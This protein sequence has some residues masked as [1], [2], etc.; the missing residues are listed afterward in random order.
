M[1][2]YTY[3]GRG[4]DI[5]SGTLEEIG[6][7]VI[8]W[9]GDRATQGNEEPWIELDDEGDT[10]P[11]DFTADEFVAWVAKAEDRPLRHALDALTER[12]I[13]RDSEIVAWLGDA[14]VT[15]E[16]YERIAAAFADLTERYPGADVNDDRI[17]A[18]SAAVRVIIG[19]DTLEAIGRRFQAARAALAAAQVE[20]TG[21][22][23]GSQ[24]SE[25]HISAR[26]GVA[27]E[28]V[29]KALGRR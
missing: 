18:T 22:I 5:V 10:S 9:H 11:R 12:T 7:R 23:V 27:R 14:E 2:T 25:Q 4:G 29:R 16:Q 17:A 8:A 28:T 24:G 19:D 20:L 13:D 21:G 6:E 15:D 3:I 26:A 1:S